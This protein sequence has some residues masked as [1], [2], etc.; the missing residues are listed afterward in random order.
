MTQ[1]RAGIVYGVHPVE[2][3]LRSGR[4]IE[5]LYLA[6]GAR[7]GRLRAIEELA[8]GRGVAVRRLD[9][10]ALDR[11]AAGG[12][13]QGV[14]AEVGA[15]PAAELEDVLAGLAGRAEALLVVLDGV[16]DP[17][18]LGAVVRN[19]A[20]TGAAAVLIP[21]DRSAG[22]TP[23]VEKVAAGGLEHVPV[24]RVGNVVQTLRKLKDDEGFWI[25]GAAGDAGAEDYDRVDFSGRVA[26][27]LGEEHGGLRR[28][29]RE[30]CDRLVRIP[31]TGVIDS[32]NLATA[33]GII[34]AR[35]YGERRRAPTDNC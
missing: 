23:V 11:M 26:L 14:A 35:I 9:A 4:P 30:H 27:V 19:A 15:R 8:R 31:S 6:E 10:R 5:T 25:F 22:V 3:A 29:T 7:G 32:F 1:P 24:V 28:L 34:L 21:K 20:L 18:N 33:S 16:Q 12:V 2:E 13:H 17:H